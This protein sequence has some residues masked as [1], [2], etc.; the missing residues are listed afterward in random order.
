MR[1][2]QAQIDITSEHQKVYQQCRAFDILVQYSN[3]GKSMAYQGRL[4]RVEPV[5]SEERVI[6]A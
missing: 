2:E 1:A 6:V 3:V 4:R 5:S